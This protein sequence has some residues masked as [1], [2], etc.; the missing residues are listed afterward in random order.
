MPA[1]PA[2]QI[3]PAVKSARKNEKKAAAMLAGRKATILTGSQGVLDDAYTQK[4]T[5]MGA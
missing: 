1:P 5:L 4:K 2:T 3:D